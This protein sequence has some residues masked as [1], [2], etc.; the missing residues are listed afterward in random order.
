MSWSPRPCYLGEIILKGEGGQGFQGHGPKSS[1]SAVP[2]APGGRG[3][4]GWGG[5]STASDGKEG[6][7]TKSCQVQPPAQHTRSPAPSS[8]HQT[9][10][11][12][13]SVLVL[14]RTVY[15][16]SNILPKITVTDPGTKHF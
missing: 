9:C 15:M 8:P 12:D 7:S 10:E 13:F 11:A 1:H 5:Q 3:G 2:A 16:E 14:Q 4:G 6:V